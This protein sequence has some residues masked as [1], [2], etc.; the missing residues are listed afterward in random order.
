MQI[1]DLEDL[2]TKLCERA[3]PTFGAKKFDDIRRKI[4]SRYYLEMSN[5]GSRT[6]L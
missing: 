1:K 5:P 6:R 4:L 2:K 3:T